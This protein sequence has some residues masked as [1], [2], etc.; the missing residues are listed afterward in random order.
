M[1]VT[2]DGVYS[3]RFYNGWLL[4]RMAVTTDGGY[5]GWLSQRMV[6]IAGGCYNGWRL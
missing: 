3:G 6:F 1:A 2:T 5:D 4:Q